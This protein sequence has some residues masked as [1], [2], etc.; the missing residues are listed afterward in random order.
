MNFRF[1]GLV[2]FGDA[3]TCIFVITHIADSAGR[4]KP[5]PYSATNTVRW[6]KKPPSRAHLPNP[7]GR[8]RLQDMVKA[9][10]PSNPLF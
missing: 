3:I 1:K 4:L 5:W 2:Y 9:G 10:D 7:Q 8:Q 6:C